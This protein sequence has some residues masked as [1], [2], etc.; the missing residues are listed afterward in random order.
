MSTYSKYGSGVE[1]HG[2][3]AIKTASGLERIAQLWVK[4]SSG[5]EKM[6][7]AVRSCFAAKRWRYNRPW[8]YKDK[9]KY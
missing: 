5:L 2:I 3:R 1:K 4:T 8:L 6:Y 7:E 9:W